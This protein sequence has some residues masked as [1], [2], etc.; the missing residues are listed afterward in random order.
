MK[1]LILDV[2]PERNYRISKDQNGAFGTANNYGSSFISLLLK[3]LVKNSVDK[4]FI[5]FFY[6]FI[7]FF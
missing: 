7:I 1:I 6:Y 4:F 3:T 5:L 2:Y